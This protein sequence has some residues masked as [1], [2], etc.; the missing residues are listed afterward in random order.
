[1]SEERDKKD[2]MWQLDPSM[3]ERQEASFYERRI[4]RPL[5][6]LGKFVLFFLAFTYPFYLVYVGLAYGGLAFWSFFLGS[7]AVIGVVVTRLGYARNFSSWGQGYKPLVGLVG[8]FLA[9]VGFY[10]SLIY[11]KLWYPIPVCLALG[12]GLYFLQRRIRKL[13]SL[14]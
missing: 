2:E 8:G 6:Q 11:L 4:Q 9:A 1:M 7:A 5:R 10:A 12:V 3:Y 14:P 13:K